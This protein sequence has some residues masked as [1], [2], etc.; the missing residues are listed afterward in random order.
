MRGHKKHPKKKKR[1]TDN[2]YVKRGSLD[3]MVQNMEDGDRRKAAAGITT[4]YSAKK[5]PPVETPAKSHQSTKQHMD[6]KFKSFE[7]INQNTHKTVVETKP[8]SELLKINKLTSLNHVKDQVISTLDN[9]EIP[10]YLAQKEKMNNRFI[11]GKAIFP[12]IARINKGDVI[13]AGYFEM[14]EAG[15]WYNLRLNGTKVIINVANK[16]E[17][18]TY[19]ITETIEGSTA[20][21]KPFPT[22]SYLSLRKKINEKAWRFLGRVCA[23]HETLYDL[24]SKNKESNQ[25]LYLLK[26]ERASLTRRI[27]DENYRRMEIE[28]ETRS[29]FNVINIVLQN[30][31]NKFK[32]LRE[33]NNPTKKPSK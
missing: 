14:N 32:K 6:E 15:D 28:K 24:V 19:I 13:Y 29:V 30:S 3:W 33:S 8:E 27:G 12:P 11:A 21:A 4:T 23:F 17:P 26:T 31:E 2:N 1:K 25:E 22:N 20:V 5:Q 7:Q 9:Q 16:P 18:G 10:I